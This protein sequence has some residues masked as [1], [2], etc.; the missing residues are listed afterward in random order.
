MCIQS[1]THDKSPMGRSPILLEDDVWLHVLHLWDNKFRQHVHVGIHVNGWFGKDK[2][3]NDVVM[4]Q[5][6]PD[7]DLWTV[8]FML[9]YLMW[10]LR[11]PY[12]D[13]VSVYLT[14]HMEGGFRYSHVV[15]NVHSELQL[16]PIAFP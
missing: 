2:R 13:I 4:H 8:A 6:A 5:P 10:V 16:T 12:S 9:H 14:G 3:P 15:T 11:T 1:G 7:V